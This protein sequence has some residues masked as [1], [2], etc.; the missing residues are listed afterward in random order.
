M[1]RF[2]LLIPLVFSL[3]GCGGCSKSSRTTE[4]S[5]AGKTMVAVDPPRFD[6]ANDWPWWRGPNRDGKTGGDAEYPL[7]WG[8]KENVVWK[9]DVPGRG[10]GSPIVVGTRVFLPTA[11]RERK[12]Q[13]LLCYDRNNG[14]L[15]WRKDVHQGKLGSAG[16]SQNTYASATP[17]CDGERVFAAFRNDG[18]IVVTALSIDGRQLWQTAV[19]KH[20]A[21]HGYGSSPVIYKELVI[22]SGDSGGYG[23]IAALHRKTGDI[24]WRKPR[25]L[26]DSYATPV[27]ANVAG[28]DQLLLSG[29]GYVISYDPMTGDENWKV[30][31]GTESMCGTIVW[32]DDVVFASG[33]Y[34]G[35]TTVAV[36]ADGSGSIVWE[37]GTSFYVASMLVAG[38]RLFGFQ[39]R[40]SVAY[41]FDA[42][43]GK[44]PL[45]RIRLR[46]G[47]YGSPTL[48]GGHV[49]APAR[50]G[51]VFV[52]DPKTGRVV[53][54]NSLG[55]EM[56]T[57]PTAA[58]GRLYLRVAATDSDGRRETLYCIG[59]K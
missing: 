11:D 32:K 38:D 15:M 2:W 9:A 14:N 21:T 24:W 48:A 52:I 10:L 1:R 13:T 41:L 29:G 3:P 8:P 40:N 46:T 7:R 53:A 25:S 47:F 6:P 16:H 23:F 33:G 30:K 39:D 43:D 44:Q 37:N 59:K 4:I 54:E 49:Y 27:V 31:A 56:D 51:V 36:K 35:Q 28:K 58:G 19:G 42:N 34:P 17:A 45:K 12:L 18:E 50:N 55:D 5:A 26:G 20:K 57:T 22:V